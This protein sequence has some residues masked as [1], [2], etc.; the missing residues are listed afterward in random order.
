[1]CSAQS[2]IAPKQSVA[3][4]STLPVMIEANVR[5]TI[6]HKTEAQPCA[7]ASEHAS[8]SFHCG[9]RCRTAAQHVGLDSCSSM[10]SRSTSVTRSFGETSGVKRTAFGLAIAP[11]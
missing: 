10:E 7:N 3:S 2:G 5:Y 11:S 1:M 8:C 4:E 6:K 9:A